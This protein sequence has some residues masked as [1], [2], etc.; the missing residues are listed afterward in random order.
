MTKA[1]SYLY[2]IQASKS[3]TMCDKKLEQYASGISQEI[4][5][6]VPKTSQAY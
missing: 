4:G 2:L 6:T 5:Y 3:A 1:S